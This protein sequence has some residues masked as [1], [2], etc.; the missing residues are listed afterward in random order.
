MV[1]NLPSCLLSAPRRR[2][3]LI[4]IRWGMVRPLA[5]LIL[6]RTVWNILLET[7]GGWYLFTTSRL[8]SCS[9]RGVVLFM[10]STHF[11]THSLV[12][13]AFREKGCELA[14]ARNKRHFLLPFGTICTLI[15]CRRKAVDPSSL[16]G[17]SHF[18]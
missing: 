16:T 5:S 14:D 11:R 10:S 2:G 6:C 9:C 15:Q 1:I 7:S 8:K 12:S 4:V 13:L 17:V 3:I 18:W